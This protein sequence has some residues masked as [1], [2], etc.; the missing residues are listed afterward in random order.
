[1]KTYRS[2]NYC[3]WPERLIEALWAYRTSVRTPTG[4]TPY[5]L[6]F[7]MEPVLPYEI[8]I[9]SLRVQLDQDLDLETC[10]ESLLAQLELIDE[11]RMMA[12]NH[13]LAYRKRLTRFYQKKV[14]GRSFRKGE[15]VIKRKFIRTFGPRA[16]YNKIGKVP[17]W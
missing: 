14:L 16:S 10:Q 9:P 15:M 5:S 7:G 13:A 8:M 12:P 6:V 11:R 1:K 2:Y 3:D 4:Q 17:L